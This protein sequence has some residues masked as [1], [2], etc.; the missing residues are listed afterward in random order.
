MGNST[1][2]KRT[3][4]KATETTVCATPVQPSGTW[5]VEHREPWLLPSFRQTGGPLRSIFPPVSRGTTTRQHPSPRQSSA[6]FFSFS[7][8]S[9]EHTAPS[10]FAA[11]D[12]VVPSAV[13]THLSVV[14]TTNWVSKNRG[15]DGLVV[16]SRHCQIHVTDS[17]VVPHS[18]TGLSAHP[19]QCCF[20]CEGPCLECPKTCTRGF[21]P[22]FSVQ[23]STAVALCFKHLE[24]E[25]ES[26]QDRCSENFCFNVE[27]RL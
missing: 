24:R 7:P 4:L 22:A 11:L 19:G 9:R 13:T 15:S 8:R 16:L 6:H 18:C 1:T 5:R 12:S 10:I 21:V 27:L 25:S 26:F 2:C 3:I 20:W 23:E 17:C 14:S